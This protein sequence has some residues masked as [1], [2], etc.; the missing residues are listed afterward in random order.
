M[1]LAG[2]PPVS[3]NPV[4]R[5][6]GDLRA[7]R[8]VPVPFPPGETGFNLR[9]TKSFADDPLTLLLDAY[10]RF[11]PVFTLRIFHGRV[12]TF[13]SSMVTSYSRW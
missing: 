7:E 12:N 1:S 4:L 9:R 6:V 11:G 13:G 8:A 3:T 10:D 2:P 5:L